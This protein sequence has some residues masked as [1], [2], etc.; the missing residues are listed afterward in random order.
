MEGERLGGG[1]MR[2][3][4]SGTG[5]AHGVGKEKMRVSLYLKGEEVSNSLV[6]VVVEGFDLGGRSVGCDYG[7][8]GH[9]SLDEK[10]YKGIG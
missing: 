1:G 6:S 4:I 2:R 3:T 5:F 8:I 7:G 10:D 9:F